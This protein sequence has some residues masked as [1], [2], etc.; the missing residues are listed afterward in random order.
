MVKKKKVLSKK[1][2]QGLKVKCV[3]KLGDKKV[4]QIYFVSNKELCRA[5]IMSY[6]PAKVEYR[7]IITPKV[8]LTPKQSL[9]AIPSLPQ[10]QVEILQ[11]FLYSTY[12]YLVQSISFFPLYLPIHFF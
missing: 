5:F 4:N 9:S 6:C 12:L 1:I 8:Y 10:Y 3:G 11:D 2:K 7:I